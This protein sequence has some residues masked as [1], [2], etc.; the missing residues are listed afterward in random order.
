MDK[1][2]KLLIIVHNTVEIVCSEISDAYF[3][4][5]SA[6]LFSVPMCTMKMS[7]FVSFCFFVVF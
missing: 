1:D 2:K 7:A 6:T 3:L 4:H 5:V